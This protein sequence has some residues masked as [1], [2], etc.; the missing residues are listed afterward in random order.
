MGSLVSR[1]ALSSLLASWST[2]GPGSLTSFSLQQAGFC[3]PAG[4]LGA[5]EVLVRWYKQVEHIWTQF[6]GLD[7][8]HGESWQRHIPGKCPDSGHSFFQSC[9]LSIHPSRQLH[10][11]SL[12]LISI[13]LLLYQLVPTQQVTPRWYN[14]LQGHQQNLHSRRREATSHPLFISGL[15]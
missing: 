13:S 7:W 3:T 4:P 10:T 9:C 6:V 14:S 1:C 2:Q 11:V 15:Q 5:Q 8:H 12:P